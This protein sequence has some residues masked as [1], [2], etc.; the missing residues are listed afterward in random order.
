MNDPQFVSPGSVVL[1]FTQ[2]SVEDIS[3]FTSV[4]DT[5]QRTRA[6]IQVLIPDIT[7]PCSL[8]WTDV[9]NRV[10]FALPQQSG[11]DLFTVFSYDLVNV[12]LP[13]YLPSLYRGAVVDSLVVRNCTRDEILISIDSYTPEL[14][15]VYSGVNPSLTLIDPTNTSISLPPNA[16]SSSFNYF[17]VVQTLGKGGTYKLIATS[18]S[19]AGSCLI[20]VHANSLIEVTAGFVIPN[21]PYNGA[22]N[23][24]AHW[25]ALADPSKS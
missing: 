9:S 15:L 25:V 11:G 2:S 12:L 4:F 23:D 10:L 16:I 19:S 7:T 24:D 8:P 6:Q 22:T 17:G 21:D 5:I 3:K 18:D 20:N 1:L 14:T 13:A